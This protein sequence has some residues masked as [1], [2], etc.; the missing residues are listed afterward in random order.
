MEIETAKI[1][2]IALI[3]HSGEGKTT[4]AE[5]LLFNA[6]VI[7]RLGRVD[8]GNTVM[9]FDAEEIAK[10]SSISLSVASATYEDYKF[11]IIDVPGFFDFEGEM[12]QA[13]CGA[14]AA[15]IVTSAQGALT[16]GTEKAIDYC[17][18]HKK[19]CVIF[20]SGIDKDN[21]SYLKTALAIHEKYP[22]LVANLF[23]PYR[24]ND[25]F[26]GYVSV[27]SGKF[28]NVITKEVGQVPPQLVEMFNRAHNE[29]AEIAAGNDEELLDKYFTDGTLSMEEIEKGINIGMRNCGLIPIMGGSGYQ[30][31]AVRYFKEKLKT[32]LPAPSELKYTVYEGDKPIELNCDPQGKVVLHVFKTIIDPFV[33]KLNIFKV[34]SGTVKV[35]QTLYNM[36]NDQEEKIS[37]LYFVRGK[38]Q[39]PVSEITAGDIGAIAKLELVR[40]GDTLCG[41][42]L[43]VKVA[44][45]EKPAPV[46][47]MAVYCAKK[48]DEDK[49]FTSLK[50]LRE[51]DISFAV[52]KDAETGQTVLQGVGDTQLSI[53]C[54]KLKNKFGCEVILKEPKIAYRETI[55]K[56]SEARGK[57]KKQSGGAGQYGDCAIR[58]EPGAS[59]GVYEFV[60][61]VVGGAVPRQF[62][63]AVDKGLREAIKC[64]VLASFPMVNLKCTLFDGSSHPVDSKEIAF[65][66][67]AKI[68]YQEGIA[69]ASPCLLEPIDNVEITIPSEYLGAV[70]GDITK[71]R[72]RILGNSDENGKMVLTC[73]VPQAEMLKYA[74]ELRSMTQG[75]GK[76]V[77][78]FERYDV[79]PAEMQEKIIK[80]YKGNE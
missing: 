43:R 15:V 64:G 68:A 30:N 21:A 77:A 18:E 73:Q 52:A 67:A 50:K 38:K 25:K 44:P 17:V 80:E 1:R 24:E 56:T 26:I 5:A 72:G 42:G 13:M 61:A 71:R 70:M 65:I 19:P 51:E 28:Y 78:T 74:L 31:F 62:I 49:V 11:N 53:I 2:N 48:G 46:Y 58:F 23:I 10:K 6:K 41:G 45:I 37:S 3:G 20:V 33:G 27:T 4:L 36:G 76:Y 34:L 75:R 55:R 63:P 29:L 12:H 47:K 40:A 39:E 22:K 35:G 54:K 57:H 7:D 66:S 8:E 59:D 32:L 14:D 79:V 60:D 69:K 9:D 16:V